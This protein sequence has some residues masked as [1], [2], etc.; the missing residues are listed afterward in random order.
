MLLS[1][2]AKVA[3]PAGVAVVLTGMGRDGAVG[4]AAVHDKGGLAISQSEESAAA[5]GM[6]QA[7]VMSGVDLVLAP[8]EIIGCLTG[9]RYAP[10]PEQ[11]NGL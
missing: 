2:I 9:L 6:P 1:S 8:D 3:G 5:F 10:L 11:G 4:A 7:A